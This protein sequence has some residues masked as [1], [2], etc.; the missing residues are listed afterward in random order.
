MI[1]FENCKNVKI[2]GVSLVNSPS[3]H[4]VPKRCENVLIDGVTILCPSIAPN[5][6]AIDPSECRNVLITNCLID[7]GDDNV[8]LKSGKQN[9]EYPNHACANITVSNCTFIHGHG[10]SIGSETVGGVFNLVVENCTFE[11]LAAGIRIKSA[12][13][14][15]GV[16]ENI[17]YRNI[18]MRNV[19]IPISLSSWYEDS[20]EDETSQPFNSLTPVFRN[21]SIK[22]VF[23]TSPCGNIETIERITDFL[24]YYYAYHDFLEPRNA[25]VIAGLPESEI[26]NVSLEN[27]RIKSGTGMT[28]R[29][30]RN[31]RMK[32][33]K[34]ET[35]DGEPFV[36]KNAQVAGLNR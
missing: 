36:V 2:I 18:F 10:M 25:G 27:I 3:F 34:I 20:G 29:N 15:G 32:N 33:V 24:Y 9:P 11:R 23:A 30:A 26:T 5:T 12:R 6:D 35:I 13:G 8:A 28:I 19:K 21:I 14:K 16:V 22:N 7:V 31:I 17:S 4:L 1:L